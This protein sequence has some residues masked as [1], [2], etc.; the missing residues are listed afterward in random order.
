MTDERDDTK[1]REKYMSK[2]T[3]IILGI[4]VAALVGVLGYALGARNNN[5][6]ET[7]ITTTTEPVSIQ[8]AQETPIITSSGV[9]TTT[10]TDPIAD[11][12]TYTNTNFNFSIK[13]PNDW[14]VSDTL[15]KDAST[16]SRGE[17]LI[18]SKNNETNSPNLTFVIN[19][20]GRGVA[21]AKIRYDIEYK[22]GNLVISNRIIN[23]S[24]DM[25]GPVDGKIHFY[26]NGGSTI[27]LNKLLYYI[28]GNNIFYSDDE[29]KIIS[30][31][32]TFRFTN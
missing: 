29:A 27:E 24:N 32:S 2:T 17:S 30:I 14:K 28:V 19:D 3:K 7:T 21:P 16:E 25:G 20:V 10:T 6:A 4:V 26:N 12:K 23:S 8:T 9:T 31:L 11:W 5:V 1:G 15:Q 18:F 22:N 13:Y